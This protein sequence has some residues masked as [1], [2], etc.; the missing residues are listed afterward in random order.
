L[1]GRA[2]IVA[3]M[4]DRTTIIERDRTL[5]VAEHR[6][7]EHASLSS[8]LKVAMRR[9]RVTANR[10][11]ELTAGGAASTETIFP[12]GSRLVLS[13]VYANVML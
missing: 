10:Y 7:L 9:S 11:A 12:S 1:R 8:A 3:G 5:A 13:F 6:A 4:A 2:P